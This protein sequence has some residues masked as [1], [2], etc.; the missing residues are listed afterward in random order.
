MAGGTTVTRR[1]LTTPRAAAVAGV[2][3]SA[4]MF[5]DLAIVR[6]TIPYDP[7]EP[8]IWLMDPARRNAVR[9]ALN[10]IPFAGIA[11]LWFVGV[12]R[13][14]L[15]VLEDRFFAT[16]FFGGDHHGSCGGHRRRQRPPSTQ[17]NLLLRPAVE[18]HVP[19]CLRHQ[20]GRSV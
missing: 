9:F 10:L 16:V 17:R 20:N 14:R 2:V 19:K 6:I 5:V 11:F 7:D 3:F 13:D 18:L 1:P 4:L 15:G 12:L 8:G